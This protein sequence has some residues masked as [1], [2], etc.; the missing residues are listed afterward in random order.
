[1]LGVC[2]VSA[3]MYRVTHKMGLIQSNATQLKIN[4]FECAVARILWYLKSIFIKTGHLFL[5]SPGKTSS[6]RV[7][8]ISKQAGANKNSGDFLKKLS[9]YFTRHDWT[10]P[11]RLQNMVQFLHIFYNSS[12][13]HS[14]DYL[15]G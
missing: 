12:E 9:V 11:S 1:M 6:S 13:Y 7:C 5:G 2:D 8:Y 4:M 10:L 3:Y 14:D 15:F